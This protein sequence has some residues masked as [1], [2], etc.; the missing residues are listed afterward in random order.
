M[1][2]RIQ[3]FLENHHRAVMVT[4]RTDGSPHV[5]IVG[6]GLV[7]GKLWSSGT[8]GRLRTKHLR[9]DPRAS[10]CV[11]DATN[12][13]AWLGLDTTVTILDGE[14]APE[15]NLALY[16]VLAGEPDD[17]ARYKE[18][19]VE[20]RRLIYEFSVVRAYGQY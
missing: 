17:V 20:E 5:A 4:L 11:L 16:R 2:K 10:L 8:R 15:Q 14:D 7:D 1:E 12:P 6:V 13:Y 9:R 19:M 3:R 18:A